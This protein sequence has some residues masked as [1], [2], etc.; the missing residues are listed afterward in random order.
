MTV[1]REVE[2]AAGEAEPTVTA[3]SVRRPGRHC[4]TGPARQVLSFFPPVG[5]LVFASPV[6]A[7]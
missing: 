3:G 6:G 1:G 7:M 2:V 5:D 4:G